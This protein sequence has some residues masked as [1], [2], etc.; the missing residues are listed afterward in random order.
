MILPDAKY[1]E[2]IQLDSIS[3]GSTAELSTEIFTNVIVGL[4]NLKDIYNRKYIKIQDVSAQVGGLIKFFLMFAD[5]FLTFYSYIPF[6]ETLY[7]KIYDY[8]TLFPDAEKKMENIISIKQKN[9]LYS[10]QSPIQNI[11]NSNFVYVNCGKSGNMLSNNKLE[12]IGKKCNNKIS[13][14]SNIVY[15]S[16]SFLEIIFRI[17]CKKKKRFLF[18]EKMVENYREN[19]D[20]EKILL[21]DL[22]L[23]YLW[24]YT[25]STAEEEVIKLFSIFKFYEKCQ[26]REQDDQDLIDSKNVNSR[27]FTKL[28]I[29]K[30]IFCEKFRNKEERDNKLSSSQNNNLI[31]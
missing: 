3:S 27:I 1:Q 5:F 10:S 22:K 14:N 9:I 21:N 24:K 29:P 20:V 28:N 23:K 7:L 6:L 30:Q 13:A 11:G 31:E 25:F 18:M 26:A 2:Y 8:N 16:H 4:N 19:Y 17:C 12:T 15:R